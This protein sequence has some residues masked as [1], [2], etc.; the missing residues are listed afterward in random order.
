MQTIVLLDHGGAVIASTTQDVE[1]ILARNARL[2]REPQRRDWARHVASIPNVILV[3]W[4]NEEHARIR[5]ARR[6]QARR[7]GLGLFKGCLM[8][9][10]I[11][12][13]VFAMWAGAVALIFALDE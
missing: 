1:P 5:R 6:P 3:K 12:L 7:P 13:S 9:I 4:L 10:L 2:R 8:P 11:L